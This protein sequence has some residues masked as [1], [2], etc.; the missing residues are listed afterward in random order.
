[1]F[2]VLWGGGLK[3]KG[4]VEMCREDYIYKKMCEAKYFTGIFN[5]ENDILERPWLYR[6]YKEFRDFRTDGLG[7][8]ESYY[9]PGIGNLDLGVTIGREW[10]GVWPEERLIVNS[11][12]DLQDTCGVVCGSGKGFGLLESTSLSL[13]PDFTYTNYVFDADLV[14][15]GVYLG[16]FVVSKTAAT[17]E[18]EKLVSMT[19]IYG[20]GDIL[21]E[22]R[23]SINKGN[24]DFLYN[25]EKKVYNLDYLDNMTDKKMLSLIEVDEPLRVVPE[26]GSSYLHIG[27]DTVIGLEDK[28]ISQGYLGMEKILYE[29]NVLP[30]SGWLMNFCFFL[31]GAAAVGTAVW[32]FYIGL[33]KLKEYIEMS[34]IWDPDYKY[35]EV[36]YNWDSEDPQFEVGLELDKVGRDLYS[37]VKE[38]NWSW[39]EGII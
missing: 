11:P 3:Y 13:V 33:G 21:S 4:K 5:A 39:L 17:G 12:I 19:R 9:Q 2:C 34:G 20:P 35:W 32:V 22:D 18:V 16:D 10:L 1:M 37:F 38:L 25:M 29:M 27:H 24:I 14:D 26:N 7:V 23:I 36:L 28:G 8:W 6:C 30:A 15:K 31:A